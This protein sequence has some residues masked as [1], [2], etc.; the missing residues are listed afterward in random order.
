MSCG[1]ATLR[2]GAET[3]ADLLRAADSALY[4]AKR[5]GR[6]RVCLAASDPRKA[7][8]EA[9]PRRGGGRGLR[10]AGKVDVASLLSIP[11]YKRMDRCGQL[12]LIAA[13]EAW[14]Q[15]GSPPTDPER[16]AVVIGSGYGGLDTTLE[17]SRTLDTS[18]PR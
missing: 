6:G 16:L 5:S 9:A 1:V 18:G 7:W 17:Q 2:L 3:P 8:R 13:R 4:L 11:E 10:D 15:A 12:A 14:A